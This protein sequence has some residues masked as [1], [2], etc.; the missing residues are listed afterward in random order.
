M[1]KQTKILMRRRKKLIKEWASVP[2]DW[3]GT[4]AIRFSGTDPPLAETDEEYEKQLKE[5]E[6]WREK[7]TAWLRGI[8]P[9]E[10]WRIPILTSM[11]LPEA[12]FCYINAAFYATIGMCQAVVESVLRREAGVPKRSLMPQIANGK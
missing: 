11:L 7:R 9:N 3:I 6:K 1:K 2:Y 4:D 10:M 12:G 5:I 8:F